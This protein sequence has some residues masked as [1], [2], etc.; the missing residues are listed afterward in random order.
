MEPQS[1]RSALW[2]TVGVVGSVLSI[3]VPH[4]IT[5]LHWVLD[6]GSDV[7]EAT[8]VIGQ[9]EDGAAKRIRRKMMTRMAPVVRPPRSHRHVIR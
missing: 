7:D 3:T 6:I 9:V 2:G 4:Y 8:R 5:S 1:S